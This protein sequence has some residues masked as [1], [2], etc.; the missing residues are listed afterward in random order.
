MSPEEEFQNRREIFFQWIDEVFKARMLLPEGETHECD[1]LC[2]R[3]H[4]DG[5]RLEASAKGVSDS[6]Y[7]F[8]NT[9]ELRKLLSGFPPYPPRSQPKA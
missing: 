8:S 1:N 9:Q 7:P 5:K 6:W 3:R 2:V 4:P